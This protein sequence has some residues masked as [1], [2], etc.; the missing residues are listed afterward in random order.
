MSAKPA[1]RSKSEN[2]R[3]RS[4][5]AW[6]RW[7][8][9]RD[10]FTPDGQRQLI[11]AHFGKFDRLARIAHDAKARSDPTEAAV[12]LWGELR[13]SVDGR[14]VQVAPP[15]PPLTPN[16]HPSCRARD[17]APTPRPSRLDLP[18]SPARGRRPARPGLAS[19]GCSRRARPAIRLK[20]ER[21]RPLLEAPAARKREAT[22]ARTRPRRRPWWTGRRG[23]P[24][25]RG[26][27]SNSAGLIGPLWACLGPDEAGGAK[28]ALYA[29]AT[30]PRAWGRKQC[31]GCNVAPLHLFRTFLL[32]PVMM[33]LGEGRESRPVRFFQWPPQAHHR[34]FLFPHAAAAAVTPSRESR[35]TL[36]RP[37]ILSRKAR[38]KTAKE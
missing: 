36:T 12:I 2:L 10:R 37:L 35:I 4:E 1:R 6:K 11:D 32:T 30:R 34:L 13:Q 3:R 38:S 21:F 9:Y 19:A 22:I 28:S 15:P 18:A 24:N 7:A 17:H 26:R 16:P 25:V 5:P 8:R 29:P 23:K 14:R 20:G 33:A 31:Q 27:P